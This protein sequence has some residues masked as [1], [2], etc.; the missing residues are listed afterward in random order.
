MSVKIV[1]W[2]IAMVCF[3]VKGC[4]VNTGQVDLFNIG[5]GF[6]MAGLLFG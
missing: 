2:F 5:C 4:G 6:V 3:F 1:L